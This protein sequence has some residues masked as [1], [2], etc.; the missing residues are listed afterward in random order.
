MFIL[1]IAVLRSHR[2]FEA[3]APY[4]Q[5]YHYFK[6]KKR[7]RKYHWLGKTCR[8]KILLKESCWSRKVISVPASQHWF[9]GYVYAIHSPSLQINQSQFKEMHINLKSSFRR[10]P[11]QISESKNN[12]SVVLMMEGLHC[13]LIFTSMQLANIKPIFANYQK[14]ETI[15]EIILPNHPESVVLAKY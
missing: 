14:L 11:K 2:K 1:F 9:I 10:L 12:I 5:K 7:W 4:Q 6:G 3:P 13:N 15:H 8:L